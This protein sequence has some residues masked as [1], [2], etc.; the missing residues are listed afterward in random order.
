MLPFCST[1]AVRR[2]GLTAAPSLSNTSP[3]TPALS[4]AW[5]G[6]SSPHCP[7]HLQSR[8]DPPTSPKPQGPVAA[9]APP[10]H[11]MT[12]PST[13]V[14]P[15]KCATA[16]SASLTCPRTT[17]TRRWRCHCLLSVAPCWGRLSE[18]GLLISTPI[19]GPSAP[20]C[21]HP[22]THQRHRS[23]HRHSSFHIYIVHQHH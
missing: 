18:A 10:A 21:D 6:R 2:M 1:T 5:M 13:F 20:R 8:P 14:P 17:R 3:A 16:A 7:C 19:L 12:H 11:L 9:T 23:S 22:V 4:L 15:M